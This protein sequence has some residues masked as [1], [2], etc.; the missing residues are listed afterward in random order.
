MLDNQFYNNASL[1]NVFK[2]LIKTFGLDILFK[3]KT[4]AFLSYGKYFNL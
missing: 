4:K 3:Y 2:T 1:M